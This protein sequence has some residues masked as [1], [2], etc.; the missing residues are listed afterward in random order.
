MV[1][2][3]KKVVVW[4]VSSGTYKPPSSGFAMYAVGIGGM[5]IA[6]R[7]R[8]IVDL[9]PVPLSEQP[10]GRRV[11]DQAT[12]SCNGRLIRKP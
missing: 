7:P 6:Y 4:D 3:A 2:I 10:T 1:A 11:A 5:P 8:P 9:H 12:I